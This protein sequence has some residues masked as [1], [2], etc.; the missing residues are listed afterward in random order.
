MAELV[1]MRHAKSDWTTGLDDFHRPLSNRGRRA[2]PLMAGWLVDNELEPTAI[3]TSA[4][5][6]A[7]DTAN[8]VAEAVSLDEARFDVEP[9]LYLASAHSWLEALAARDDDRLLI[10][11]HNPGL[12]DLVEYL[13]ASPLTYTNDGKL[14]T[15]AAIAVFAI[16]SWTELG[17]QSAPLRHLVRP[18]E[19]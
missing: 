9:D 6:R 14:M 16:D 7:R 19:L 3:L 18:R 12:D 1:V 4:A 15:T 11:G 8:Y 2:A 13:S 10:C 5:T 17:P